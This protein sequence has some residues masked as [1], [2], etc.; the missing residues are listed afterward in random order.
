MYNMSALEPY[1]NRIALS[2]IAGQFSVSIC[3]YQNKALEARLVTSRSTVEGSPGPRDAL[4]QQLKRECE[5][6]ERVISD[7]RDELRDQVQ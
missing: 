1:G 2:M 6:K 3:L 5:G 7:L 4:L